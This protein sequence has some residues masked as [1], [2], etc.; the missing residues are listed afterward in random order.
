M[1]PFK[2]GRRFV[3]GTFNTTQAMLLALNDLIADGAFRPVID[4]SY[5]IEQIRDAHA[6]VDTK[7]KRGS[8]VVT[9]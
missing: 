6:Y 4:R 1:N 3:T 5:P 8:V 7:R 2:G 9:V